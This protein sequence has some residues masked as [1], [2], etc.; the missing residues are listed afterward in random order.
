MREY[1]EQEKEKKIK[2]EKIS[3]KLENEFQPESRFE[4]KDDLENNFVPSD[5]NPNSTDLMDNTFEPIDEA[6]L[7]PKSSFNSHPDEYRRIRD[8][9]QTEERDR[10][11][12]KEKYGDKGKPIEII[13]LTSEENSKLAKKAPQEIQKFNEEKDF[14]VFEENSEFAEMVGIIL[15][16]GSIPKNESHVRITLNK[17]EE[18]QYRRYVYK[19]MLKIFKKKPGI[20]KPKDANA[21]KMTICGKKIVRGL[22]NKGLKPGDKK[23]NQ[24]DVPQ[25]IKKKRE[26]R[27]SNIRGLIDTDGSIHIHKINK[28]LRITFKNSSFP[29]VNDYK[30]MCESFNIP[31]QKIYHDKK[32]DIYDAQ[33][34]AKKD[35]VNFIET[36]NP[37]KWEYRAKTFGL[38]LKSI[39]NPK[40]RELIEKELIK[41]YPD[42]KVHYSK[43]YYALLKRLCEKYEYDVSDES[44]FNEL[45]DALTYSDNWTGLKKEQKDML[46]AKAK[47]LI[48]NLKVKLNTTKK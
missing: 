18:T 3:E 40:K 5:E 39:S 4:E 11:Y 29:L 16:D 41:P 36:I 17:T 45:E 30:E 43:K 28:N 31:T 47:N 20:Y 33:I 26:N 2:S 1:T 34:E 46:N 14:V 21:V 37:R 6:E 32:R 44:I 12:I 8:E 35:I 42:K 27:R 9:K 7:N 38:V 15:G 22:V 10:K 48:S 24:V 25:W 13:K 23:K 19:S